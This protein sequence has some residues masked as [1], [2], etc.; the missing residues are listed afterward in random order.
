MTLLEE[1]RLRLE[2]DGYIG[3]WEEDN[4]AVSGGSVSMKDELLKGVVATACEDHRMH[5]SGR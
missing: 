3:R 1:N 4:L 2:M 5:W